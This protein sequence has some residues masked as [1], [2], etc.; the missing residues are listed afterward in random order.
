MTIQNIA[1]TVAGFV[2]MAA[3]AAAALTAWLLVTAP[4]TVAVALNSHDGEPFVHAAMRVL[5]DV[6][7]TLVRYL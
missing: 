2:M 1:T 7:A 6:L 5:H 4:T 3:T